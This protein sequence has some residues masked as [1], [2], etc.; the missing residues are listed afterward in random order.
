MMRVL[1]SLPAQLSVFN[2]VDSLKPQQY[3][4]SLYSA[5]CMHYRL[6]LEG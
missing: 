2:S 6:K 3:N 1:A 5:S 4:Q